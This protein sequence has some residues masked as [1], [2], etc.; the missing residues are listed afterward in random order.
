MLSLDLIGQWPPMLVPPNHLTHG[1][2]LT[3]LYG[4]INF[5]IILFINT[6]TFIMN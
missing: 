3:L 1:T 2:L 6:V 4:T 5:I